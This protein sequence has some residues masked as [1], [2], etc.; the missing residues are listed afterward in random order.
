MK[1]LLALVVFK[2]HVNFN[3]KK[4]AE[5]ISGFFNISQKP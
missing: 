5:V 1:K 4:T 3:H 2:K